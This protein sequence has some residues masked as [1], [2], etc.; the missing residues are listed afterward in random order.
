MRNKGNKHVYSEQALRREL[1]EYRRKGCIVC[2]NGRP[3]APEKIISAC[4]R[5]KGSYMRDFVSDE[6]ERV[7][8]IDF[9]KIK[10]KE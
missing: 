7:E 5:E 3:S 1:E 4:L 10:E 9:I 8:K 2:L 6:T